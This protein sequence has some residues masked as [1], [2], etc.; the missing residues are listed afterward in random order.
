MNARGRPTTGKCTTGKQDSEGKNKPWFL[1][2]QHIALGVQYPSGPA[3]VT[4]KILLH[5]RH[6]DK[7]QT[8]TIAHNSQP[9]SHSNSLA[10]ALGL[11]FLGL[12]SPPQAV[13]QAQQRLARTLDL[14][15]AWLQLSGEVMQKKLSYQGR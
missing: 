4:P 13:E 5:S 10:L 8:E 11:V 15:V 7:Q 12:L 3:L 14:L 6:D 1:F 2:E 9:D